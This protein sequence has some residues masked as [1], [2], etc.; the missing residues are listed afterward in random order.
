MKKLKAHVSSK[1]LKK[2]IN[3]RDDQ[4][5]LDNIYIENLEMYDIVPYN[6]SLCSN[7]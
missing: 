2:W 7:I 4:V 3:S 6:S 5:F 1:K